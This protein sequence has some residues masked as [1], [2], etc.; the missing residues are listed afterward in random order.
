MRQS[1]MALLKGKKN[2]GVLPNYAIAKDTPKHF[3]T[4]D[5]VRLLGRVFKTTVLLLC[6]MLILLFRYISSGGF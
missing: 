6:S 3:Q 5:P 4:R 1:Y 2:I